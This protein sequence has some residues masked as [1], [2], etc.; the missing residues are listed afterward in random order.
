MRV[1]LGWLAEF[2]ALPDSQVELEER[3]TLGG[4][5]I[6][7]VARTGPDLDEIRVGHVLERE[8]HPDADR[9]SVCKVDL[10]GDEPLSIVCGAPNVAAGQKVA[11][12]TPGTILP[13]GTKLKKSKIRGVA[14]MGMICSASELGLSDEHDGIMVLDAA[15][16]VGRPIAEY[17]SAGQVV[18]DLEITPN[19]GDW[20][21]MLGVAREV[22]AQFGGSIK[23]PPTQPCESGSAAADLIRIEIE[24]NAGCH[25]YAGRVVHG[26]KVG[27]SPEWLVEKVEAA[28]MRS[29]NIVVD[30]TNL[31]L[32]EFGQPLH[33]F[34]LS[35]LT[36]A[37]IRVRS[38]APGEPIETLDGVER[39]LEAGDLVIADAKRAI[40]IAGVMG[41][42]ATEV[43]ES[44]TDILLESAHFAPTRIRK[45][46]RRLGL[47]TEASYRFER[48]VDHEGVVRA[49]DR[50][51][52]LLAELAGGEVATGVVEARGDPVSHCDRVEI[53]VA[54][55]NRMLGT[56]LTA[57]EMITLLERVDI[58]AN[59]VRGILSCSVPSY[60][61]DISIP[62]DIVEEVARVYGYDR[63]PTTLPSARLDSPAVPTSY[64][65]ADR[66]RD[67]LVASGLYETRSFP[68]I[69]SKDWDAI[70]LPDDDP[71][72]QSVRIVNPIVEEN[73]EMRTTLVPSLLHAAQGN[74]ARQVA[75][76]RLFEVAHV[77]LPTA[78]DALPREEQ[79]VTAL[80][81]RPQRA[82]LWEQ[83]DSRDLFFDAK[84]IA[85]V[86][87][88]DLNREPVFKTG[89]AESFL[90]PGASVSVVSGGQTIGTV[91]ELHPE[92]A[93]YFEIDVPCALIDLSLHQLERIS[94]KPSKFEAVSRQPA[95]SRDIAVI[96]SQDRP[97]GELLEAIRKTAGSA[98]VSVGVF[99]RYAGKGVP[100]GKVSLGVRMVFQRV[101]RTM[102]DSEVSK[103]VDRIVSMLA[104]KFDGELRSGS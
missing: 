75:D 22:R 17:V 47:F 103:L 19:R 104:H 5:E 9:L 83:V 97:A 30:I 98:L 33:A 39:K 31:V 27:P 1:G 81:T 80:I 59:E 79:R 48:G 6:E 67:S 25:R 28:G 100:E 52:R 89:T 68:G 50:A 54:K 92:V 71:R 66:V 36:D 96:L 26:V 46:A 63:L 40:A 101:D 23:L 85:E 42:A 49:A 51:A 56:E 15:A 84:G 16:Q 34:D 88:R 74:F 61:G 21:S 102:K 38:A 10:G 11:V 29:I 32:L 77:F 14:S 73:A 53:P 37:V 90:H 78:G 2:I 45:T 69:S 94:A 62:V 95:A 58:D 18:L 70:R 87:L 76:V 12:A 41:G 93:A 55:A 24:D 35:M 72:R 86:L 43:G 8:Q 13:D 99:D 4:L 3:L 57:T 60:R 64:T 7:G 20:A 91:G 65:M 44:T 82:S